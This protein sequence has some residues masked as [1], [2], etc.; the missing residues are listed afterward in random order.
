MYFEN[1]NYKFEALMNK[2]Q[3]LLEQRSNMSQEQLQRVTINGLMIGYKD[4]CNL[5]GLN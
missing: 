1:Q 2:M 3:S 4:P 5:M